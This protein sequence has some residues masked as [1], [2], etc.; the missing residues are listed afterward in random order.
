MPLEP[1]HESGAQSS[2]VSRVGQAILCYDG[3]TR[4]IRDLA[5]SQNPGEK[6]PRIYAPRR[7]KQVDECREI[8]D[9]I[10]FQ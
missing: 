2:A 8:S 4:L 3:A 7:F 5:P 10:R 6:P 9:I 1:I